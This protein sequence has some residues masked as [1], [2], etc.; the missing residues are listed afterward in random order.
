MLQL[1]NADAESLT[2][3]RAFH[4]GITNKAAYSDTATGERSAMDATAKREV[5]ILRRASQGL[6]EVGRKILAMNA[7]FLSEEEVVRVTHDEFI[8]VRRDDLAGEFD[9]KISTSTAESDNQKAEELAFMLQTTAQTMGP[10]FAQIILADI[11]KLRKMP[12]LAKKIEEYKAPPPDPLEQQLKELEIA[13][14]EAEVLKL[15]AEAQ[16]KGAEAQLDQ[17]K[18]GTE[19]AKARNLDAETDA[20]NLDFVEQESGTKQERDLQLQSEQARGN[21]Q[22]KIVEA[23]AKARFKPKGEK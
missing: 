11:A 20:I 3:V 4:T 1:Q 16:E 12:S 7:V 13:K 22:M 17:T 8:T 9:L 2:G 14:L 15:Q 23:A 19:E 5:G 21:A 18:I 10:E 6:V